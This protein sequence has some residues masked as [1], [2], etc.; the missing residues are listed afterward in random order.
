MSKIRCREGFCLSYYEQQIDWLRDDLSRRLFFLTEEQIEIQD[1]QVRIFFAPSLWQ[2][3]L[4]IQKIGAMSAFQELEL[5]GDRWAQSIQNAKLLAEAQLSEWA[6]FGVRIAGHRKANSGLPL[7]S[8][9]ALRESRKNIAAII[10][11]AGPSLEFCQD[12]IPYDRAFV[13]A[14]GSALS[15]LKKAPH[16][17]VSVC[18][19]S[20]L[21]RGEHLDTPLCIQSRVH[22]QSATG[23]LLLVDDDLDGGWTV[24]NTA[25]SLALMLGCNPIVL[26]GVDLCYAEG[27]KYA[28]QITPSETA[29]LIETVDCKGRVV[30]TQR[31]WL[32]AAHWLQTCEKRNPAIQFYKASDE[33]L[34]SFIT[35]SLNSFDWPQQVNLPLPWQQLPFLQYHPPELNFELLWSVWQP[36][37]ERELMVDPHP[38]PI[39]DKLL[40]Q[41]Q[42]FLERVKLE[43][44]I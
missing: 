3:Q 28:H 6:D 23:P 37:F 12:Q 26:A 24:G 20:P 18:P 2:Q 21:S 42:L 10:V 7:R 30:Q 44:G 38:I 34:C 40:I 36:L 19:F 14:A 16:L 33:G 35:K 5:I 11:G 25:V 4:A 31:D 8:F 13:I 1:A 39:E 17:A 15:L 27:R 41:K 43:H 32:A 29:S 22:P 9:S